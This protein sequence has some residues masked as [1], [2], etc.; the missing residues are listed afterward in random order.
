VWMLLFEAAACGSDSAA[1]SAAASVE[2]A[3]VPRPGP[4]PVRRMTHFE[5]DNTVRDL[6]GDDSRPSSAFPPDERIAVFANEAK[7]QSVTRLLAEQYMFS[8][9]TLAARAATRWSDLVECATDAD[10]NTCAKQFAETLGMLAFRRPLDEGDEAD[11]LGA[12]A[13]G[14]ADGDFEDG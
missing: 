11:L 8:A 2:A 3:C 9:E 13:E 7:S 12:F 6:L 5:Y 4:S 14:R 10:E 1:P